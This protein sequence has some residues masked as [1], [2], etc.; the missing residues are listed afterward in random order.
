ML[1]PQ[2][3]PL[4][5]WAAYF[6]VTQCFQVRHQSSNHSWR[7]AGPELPTFP[8][9]PELQE[10]GHSIPPQLFRGLQE[11]RDFSWEADP[12]VCAGDPEQLCCVRS[13]DPSTGEPPVTAPA[14]PHIVFLCFN[15]CLPV[16]SPSFGQVLASVTAAPSG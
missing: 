16:P 1:P 8:R 14:A 10:P 11:G 13:L 7:S 4:A 15:L 9:V 6:G 2:A 12:R 3:R 5:P